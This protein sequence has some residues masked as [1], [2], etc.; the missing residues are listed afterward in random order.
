M[1][2]QRRSVVMSYRNKMSAKI[3]GGTIVMWGWNNICASLRDVVVWE[4]RSR[5]GY[6]QRLWLHVST[7]LL[8][9]GCLVMEKKSPALCFLT[10]TFAT[11]DTLKA[12]ECLASEV[13]GVLPGS[14]VFICHYVSPD[15]LSVWVNHSFHPSGCWRSFSAHWSFGNGRWYGIP[16][17]SRLYRWRLSLALPGA[18][19]HCFALCLEAGTALFHVEGHFSIRLVLKSVSLPICLEYIW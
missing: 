5:N 18:R 19:I 16:N 3:Q 7:R 2:C 15:S 8:L 14:P 17:G 1:K 10:H 9:V 13:T 12:D 11:R 6:L 4:K